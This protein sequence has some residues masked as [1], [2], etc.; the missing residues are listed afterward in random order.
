MVLLLAL[1]LAVIPKTRDLSTDHVFEKTQMKS[2]HLHEKE[3]EQ[4]SMREKLIFENLQQ[5]T[6]LKGN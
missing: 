4:L 5:N 6:L 2:A 1:D 3:Y